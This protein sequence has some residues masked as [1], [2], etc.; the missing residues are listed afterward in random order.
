[1]H[2]WDVWAEGEMVFME[3]EANAFLPHQ[4]RKTASVLLGVGL[5]RL[6][7]GVLKEIL[8]GGELVPK[9]C[10]YLPARGLCLMEVKYMKP[11]TQE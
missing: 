4:V 1:M 3:A 11:I 8:D 2:R 6:S 7:E 5:G 9:R 10:A